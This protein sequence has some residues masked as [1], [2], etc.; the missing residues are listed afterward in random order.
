MMRCKEC[1]REFTK[2]EVLNAQKGG[3]TDAEFG[4]APPRP[5][6]CLAEGCGGVLENLDP[7]II[8]TVAV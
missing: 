1:H 3:A 5:I 7:P 4:L 2:T 8:P 6:A